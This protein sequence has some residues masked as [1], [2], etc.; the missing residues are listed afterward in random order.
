MLF[1]K[2]TPGLMPK[3]LTCL[4]LTLGFAFF[5]QAPRGFFAD[6]EIW[7]IGIARNFSDEIFHPWVLTRIFFYLPLAL[8]ESAFR[9]PSM[10]VLAARAL[11]AINGLLIIGLTFRA[12]RRIHSF[13]LAP[14]IGS[15]F[16]VTTPLFFYQGYRVRSDLVATTLILAFG[17]GSFATSWR[18]YAIL[19]LLATPKAVI[20]L[21]PTIAFIRFRPS[22]RWVWI[23]LAILLLGLI[24]FPLYRDSLNFFINSFAGSDIVPSYFSRRRFFYVTDSIRRAVPLFILVAARVITLSSRVFTADPARPSP[25]MYGAPRAWLRYFFILSATVLIFPEKLPYFLASILPFYII[26]SMGIFDDIRSISTKKTMCW[27]TLVLFSWAT[28]N[29]WGES[30][31][32][33]DQS[34]N[35]EQLQVMEY[36][37]SM[38]ADYPAATYFDGINMLPLRPNLRSFVGPGQP[39]GNAAAMGKLKKELPDFVFYT[40]RLYYLEPELT[41][42]LEVNYVDL[43]A[44]IFVKKNGIKPFRHEIPRHLSELF[45]FDRET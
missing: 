37:N 5:L 17:F 7:S 32:H 12:I 36:L 27:A 29:L 8:V 40:A 35:H 4:L 18:K 2:L 39:L 6:S 15:L 20:S 14:W 38:L 3:I 28:W 31:R 44:G 34:S 23:G 26:F 19:S 43:G 9:E 30:K 41:L 21:I 24:S 11:M 25:A 33:S 16:L 10:V 1:R 42:F 13:A 22:R 45:R